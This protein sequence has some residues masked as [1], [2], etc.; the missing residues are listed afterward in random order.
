MKII[1]RRW[2]SGAM[3][4]LIDLTLMVLLR[5][6]AH[7]YN[8]SRRKLHYYGDFRTF[9]HIHLKANVGVTDVCVNNIADL[10]VPFHLQNALLI[11]QEFLYLSISSCISCCICFKKCSNAYHVFTSFASDKSSLEVS[12]YVACICTSIIKIYYIKL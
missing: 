11:S 9:V 8:Y 4:S 7:D 6:F 10:A 5:R 2:L 1:K 12:L 3:V